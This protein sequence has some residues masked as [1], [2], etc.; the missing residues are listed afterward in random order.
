MTKIFKPILIAIFFLMLGNNSA[1][2][3]CDEP[4]TQ[5]EMNK[6][7]AEELAISD[8]ELNETYQKYTKDLS[9]AHLDALKKA[10]NSWIKYRD[11]ACASYG[12]TAEG[13]SMEG[14]LVSLCRARLTA[15]RTDLLTE[16]FDPESGAEEEAPK[17]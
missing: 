13:G 16:Q 10:Q 12:L 9:P 6:C 11:E 2:A 14:M 15:E 17:E 8:K 5:A 3:N 1:W 7:A 4:Q